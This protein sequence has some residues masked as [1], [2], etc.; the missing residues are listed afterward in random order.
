MFRSR[1][2]MTLIELVVALAVTGLALAAGVAAFGSVVDHRERA[3]QATDEIARAA[4]L[5]QTLESWL[6]GAQLGAYQG[7]A[8]FQGLDAVHEG[9]P[10]DQILFQTTAPASPEARSTRVHL[11]VDRDPLTPSAAWSRSC[12]P[13]ARASRSASSSSRG[14]S[15][16]IFATSPTSPASDAGCR[17]G[18]RAAASLWAS[19]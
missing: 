7:A 17:A 16:S 15:A 9:T 4:A 8:S 1:A 3:A 18:F 19:R 5:R 11:Y 2:G 14:S 12:R 6:G 10:D 13:G